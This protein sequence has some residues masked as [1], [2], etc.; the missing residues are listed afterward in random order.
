MF[1]RR[2][3]AKLFQ[4]KIAKCL[5]YS[6]NFALAIMPIFILAPSALAENLSIL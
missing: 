2:N 5:G 4:H 6:N 1:N 3:Q